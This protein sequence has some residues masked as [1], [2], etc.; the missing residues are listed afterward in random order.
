[1][2]LASFLFISLCLST[3]IAAP[4]PKQPK[5]ADDDLKVLQGLW[6][7]VAL[8]G[9]GMNAPADVVKGMRCEFKDAEARFADPG[10]ELHDKTTVKLDCSKSPMEIDLTSLEGIMKGKTRKGIFKIEDGQL[11]LCVGE[12]HTSPRPTDFTT[13]ADSHRCMLT[14]EHGKR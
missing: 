1:M 4:P 14:F 8:E 10:E 2:R 12:T 3:V 11:I 13:K 6:L 5:P 9:D 7:V